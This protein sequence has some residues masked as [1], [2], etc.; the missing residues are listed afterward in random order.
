MPADHEQRRSSQHRE[1]ISSAA[2]ADHSHLQRSEVERFHFTLQENAS[3]LVQGSDLQEFL[4]HTLSSGAALLK[5]D[6]AQIFVFN[7]DDKTFEFMAGVRD[8][9]TQIG[10]RPDEPQYL[11]RF[12]ATICPAYRQFLDSGM[13]TILADDARSLHLPEELAVWF[14]SVGV[15]EWL[16]MMLLAGGEPVGFMGMAFFSKPT[17]NSSEWELAHALANQAALGMQ[18]IRL[19]DQASRAAVAEERNRLAREI[20]DTMGQEFAGIS[21]HLETAR[22]T[23]GRNPDKARECI[24]EAIALARH[25]LSEVRRSIWGLRPPDL[26]GVDLPSAIRQFVDRIRNPES[27]RIDVEVLGPLRSLPPAV[28]TEL[29]R[30]VQEALNNSLKHGHAQWIR[31]SLECSNRLVKITIAD[32]GRGFTPT[33]EHL[34]RGFGLI[35]MRERADR[36]GASFSMASVPGEGT[37]VSVELPLQAENEVTLE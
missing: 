2:F 22:Q 19:T 18:L 8:G 33:T 5:A 28:E 15:K 25:G 29:F 30:I 17:F 21:L 32:N 1:A 23:L 26:E 10:L 14:D 6:I 34:P 3:R 31:I 4:V 36:I 16:S 24:D 13:S 27:P 12:S 20:H 9:Q 37:D 11:Q 7:A 35:S